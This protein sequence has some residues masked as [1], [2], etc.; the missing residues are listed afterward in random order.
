M[1]DLG[2]LVR[3]RPGAPARSVRTPINRRRDRHGNGAATPARCR[4][5]LKAAY[6]TTVL[7]GDEPIGA[8]RPEATL[9]VSG[10]SAASTSASKR[11][12]AAC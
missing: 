7:A 11:Y 2:S 10:P 5:A 6:E 3:F 8:Q 1:N 9:R 12:L 4:G